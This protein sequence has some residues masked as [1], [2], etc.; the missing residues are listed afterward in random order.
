MKKKPGRIKAAI[1]DWLGVSDY[2][3]SAYGASS[4]TGII[5]TD[6]KMLSVS[7]VWACARLISETIDTLPLS[8]YERTSSGK[9]VSKQHPLHLIIND[10]P[11]TDTTATGHWGADDAPIM[12]RGD[13]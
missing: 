5:V 3:A 8:V 7:A 2:V 10:L 4:D 1:L 11:N 12:S 9:R 13:G 6:Q